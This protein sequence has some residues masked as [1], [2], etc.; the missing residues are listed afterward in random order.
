MTHEVPLPECKVNWEQVRKH[1]EESVGVRSQVDKNGQQIL[2]IERA[3]E[4]HM[5]DIKDINTNVANI[6]LDVALTREEVKNAVLGIKVWVLGGMLLGILTL[7]TAIVC[8]LIFFGE[9]KNQIQVKT[10]R[11]DKIES[12]VFK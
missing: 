10:K 11:L 9:N 3:L 8:G 7:A 2:T 12:A 1:H 4:S 6:K 5:Q